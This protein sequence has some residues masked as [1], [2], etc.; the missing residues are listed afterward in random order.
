MRFMRLE[1]FG[2][3]LRAVQTS[4]FELQPNKY[5]IASKEGVECTTY[6]AKQ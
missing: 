4:P 6:Q 2:Y 5:A 3:L 1:S